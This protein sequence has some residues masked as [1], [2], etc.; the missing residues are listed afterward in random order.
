MATSMPRIQN[1]CPWKCREAVFFFRSSRVRVL[2]LVLAAAIPAGRSTEAIG[3]QAVILPPDSA[4]RAF[5]QGQQALRKGDPAT[6][7][8][9][10]RQA[11]E[12]GHDRPSPRLG[13]NRY[14]VERYDPY[15]W[16]GVALMQ[17]G[18]RDEARDFLKRSASFG[19]IQ[20]WP[21][22][23]DLAR[24][25]QELSPPAPEATPAAPPVPVPAVASPT[26]TSPPEPAPV[27]RP[28][29]PEGVSPAVSPVT[30]VPS[31]APPSPSRTMLPPP[32]LSPAFR[33]DME[34]V[35]A[36]AEKA[37]WTLAE[38]RLRSLKARDPELPQ[39]ALIEAVLLGSR[40]LLEGGRDETMRRRAREAL[41]EFRRL[42][43]TA[44]QEAVWLSPSLGA[45]LSY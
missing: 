45:A 40:Y 30:L 4:A 12:T 6:A 9:F 3:A 44:R 8:D 2:L 13:T 42:G 35:L 14:F 24:R 29:A 41:L 20:Q 28:P 18:E 43:G 5:T 26:A 27:P 38:S 32:E 10:F 21:E 19:L 31:P 11:L 17:K 36:A 16:M 22:G 37:D 1:M 7:I 23:A 25:L 39:T 34:K 33:A 15:Y